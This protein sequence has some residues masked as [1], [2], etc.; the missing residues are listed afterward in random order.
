MPIDRDI[1]SRVRRLSAEKADAMTA[2][3]LFTSREF[4]SYAQSVINAVT[5][6]YELKIKLE[7]YHGELDGDTAATNNRVITV[8]THHR[9]TYFFD[10]LLN[11]FLSQMGGRYLGEAD[12]GNSGRQIF[13][14]PGY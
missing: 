10:S 8:N 7:A 4:L 1:L 14:N 9:R 3:K 13:G 2:D 11:K 6:R 12:S 5:G